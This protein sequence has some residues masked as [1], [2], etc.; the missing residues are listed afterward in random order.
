MFIEKIVAGLWETNAYLVG[1]SGEAII[2][3]PGH[4]SAEALLDIAEE[5]GFTIKAIYLTHSHFDH[6]ADV[7]V[8]K[9]HANIPVYVSPED[10]E[11]LRSP[12]SDGLPNVFEKE[13]TEPDGLFKEG[14]QVTF[15]DL[16]F[17]VIATPGHSPGSVCFYFEKEKVLFSGDTLFRSG[18]GN[19]S[20]PTSDRQKMTL[21]LKKLMTLPS[22]TV[23][24][25]GH[26]EHTTIGEERKWC[27]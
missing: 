12:G 16:S 20:F 3:D 13:G 7:D 18:H 10:A 22:D 19:T 23:V 27:A 5:R 25:P 14:D 9:R 1:S 26:G 2:I 4:E 24:Y 21:S 15:G 6:F 8:L 11:N 17:K